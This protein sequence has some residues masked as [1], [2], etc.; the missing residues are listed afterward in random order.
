M[1]QTVLVIDD[2]PSTRTFL[3][4]A[5]ESVGYRVVQASDGG[6]LPLASERQP[7][8]ILLDMV[9]P[10]MDG[11]EVSRRLRDDPATRHIPIIGMSRAEI[12]ASAAAPVL[13]DRLPKP[14][15]L[16]DLYDVVARW[17][18]LSD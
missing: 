18:S 4:D 8:V 3:T 12:V 9:M 17:A 2:D 10:A 11:W 7:A 1:T 16:D 15:G 13:D 14:F 5:L 6:A